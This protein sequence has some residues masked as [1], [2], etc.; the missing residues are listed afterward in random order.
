MLFEPTSLSLLAYRVGDTLRDKYGVDPAPIYEEVGIDPEGPK[1][2]GERIPN[3]VVNALLERAERYSGDPGVGIKVGEG[4]QP[5]HFFVL[6][7]IWLASSNLGEAIEKHLR[8]ESIM[9]SGDTDLSFELRDGFYRLK[10]AYPNPADYPGKLRLDI[11]IASLMTM[12]RQALGRPVYAY[13]LDLYA[14]DD[15]PTGIYRPFVKGPVLLNDEH[16]ALYFSAEDIEAPLRGRIPDVA[17]ATCRIADRYME[18]LDS[19]RVA[20]QVRAE[21]VQLLPGGAV[22]QE[23]IASKLYRSAST[24]QRQLSNEGTSYRD[25]LDETRRE[26]AE[27]YLR[28]G[29]HSLAQT[30]FLVGF[31]DQSNFARAFKRWTGM[32]PGEF[33]KSA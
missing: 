4:T 22:D 2:A 12:C 8:Y 9:N 32:S 33:R 5:S 31:S 13:R 17:D 14:P 6:G 30:A 20:H 1:E 3:R 23:K 27:A 15:S 24:L 16:N 21:L 29:Q 19:S 11:T 25:V 18:S 7:H 28:D 26:L 10:E